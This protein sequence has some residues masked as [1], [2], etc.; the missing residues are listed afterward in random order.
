MIAV[1]GYDI[2]IPLR[3]KRTIRRLSVLWTFNVGKEGKSRMET[4]FSKYPL[5][6]KK[7]KDGVYRWSIQMNKA[8]R[9]KLLAHILRALAPLTLFLTTLVFFAQQS[10]PRSWKTALQLLAVFAVLD[11]LALALWWLFSMKGGKAYQQYELDESH[12][13][14]IADIELLD[15]QIKFVRIRRIEAHQETGM[16]FVK[17]YLGGV[18]LFVPPED[19]D[20]VLRIIQE[21]RVASRG[22]SA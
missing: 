19:F 21:K 10:V 11:G 2:R 14:Q 8:Q 6:V 4:N 20:F 22:C 1:S 13:R 16:I 7:A 17:G 3:S 5:R 12:M 15:E 9:R 18:L